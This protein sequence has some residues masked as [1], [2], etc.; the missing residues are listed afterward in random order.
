MLKNIY[1]GEYDPYYFSVDTKEA[2]DFI[3][4]EEKSVG[5]EYLR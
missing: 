4:S 2:V 5:S 3:G 1:N